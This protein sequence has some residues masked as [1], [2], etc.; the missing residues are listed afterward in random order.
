MMPHTR[1]CKLGKEH[2]ELLINV[3]NKNFIQSVNHKLDPRK[4]WMTPRPVT[5]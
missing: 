1:N 4:R 3:R 5:I 2:R